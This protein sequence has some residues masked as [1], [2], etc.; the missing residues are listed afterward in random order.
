MGWFGV[1]VWVGGCFLLQG[2]TDEVG[3]PVVGLLRV[4]VVDLVCV[5]WRV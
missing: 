4:V 2:G 1:W 3:G 5:V